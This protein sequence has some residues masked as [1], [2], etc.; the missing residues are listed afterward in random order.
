MTA[1]TPLPLLLCLALGSAGAAAQPSTTEPPRWLG[2]GGKPLPFAT[3]DEVVEFLA[4]APVVDKEKAGR[5]IGGV[6]KLTLERDGVSVHAAFRTVEVERSSMRSSGSV[7]DRHLFRDHYAFEVAAYR[8]SR[9]LGLDRVPPT[10]ARRVE[11]RE[12]SLQL[13]IEDGITEADMI[14]SGAGKMDAARHAQRQTM[15]VFDNLIYNFDR[16]Q[17]NVLYDRSGRLWYI[18][19]TRSFKRLPELPDRERIAVCERGFLERLRLLD[20]ETIR[21]EL[22]PYLDLLELEALLGRRKMLLEH[23]DALI[24]ERGEERVLTE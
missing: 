24:A 5:G 23:F 13:W 7:L 22:K 14:E 16:H 18:D 9:L 12:G 8:L 19:H 4:T 21:R 17:N 3:E 10:A 6:V 11:G 2:A 1:R 15:L 20:E